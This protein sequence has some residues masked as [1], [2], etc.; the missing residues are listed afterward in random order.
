MSSEKQ[1][2]Y[3]INNPA[4]STR[5][6]H[7]DNPDFRSVIDESLTLVVG[8]RGGVKINEAGKT[9]RIT[10]SELPEYLSQ[11]NVAGKKF[12]CFD[13]VNVH[14]KLLDHKIKGIQEATWKLSATCSLWDVCLLQQQIAWITKGQA[15]PFPKI[16]SLFMDYKVVLDPKD[17]HEG[18]RELMR[19]QFDFLVEN[20]PYLKNDFVGRRI[21][22]EHEYDSLYIDPTE[23]IVSRRNVHYKE[24][25]WPF[26]GLIEG[27]GKYGPAAVGIEVQGAIVADHLSRTA[28]LIC[29]DPSVFYDQQLKIAKQIKKDKRIASAYPNSEAVFDRKTGEPVY[30]RK[31][32]EK[33]THLWW[34]ETKPREEQNPNAE[35]RKQDARQYRLYPL[36][37]CASDNKTADYCN[38]QHWAD[39][40]P[41]IGP[42]RLWADFDAVSKA[43]HHAETK[44]QESVPYESFPFLGSE[45]VDFVDRT[46]ESPFFQAALG[47]K[48]VEL[49]I[50][51]LDLFCFSLCNGLQD[52]GAIHDNSGTFGDYLTIGLRGKANLDEE[53]FELV[54]YEASITNHE[55]NTFGWDN[56]LTLTN[57]RF[58][59]ESKAIPSLGY[60]VLSGILFPDIL[61]SQSSTEEMNSQLDK[62]SF[63][64]NQDWMLDLNF[65]TGLEELFNRGSLCLKELPSWLQNN[66][67]Y[68]Q[69]AQIVVE[70]FIQGHSVDSV[71]QYCQSRFNHPDIPVLVKNMSG[72]LAVR[73]TYRDYDSL[74]FPWM[75]LVKAGIDP[76]VTVPDLGHFSLIVDGQVLVVGATE[77]DAIDPMLRRARFQ[78]A[79]RNTLR[80]RSSKEHRQIWTEQILPIF[81]ERFEELGLPT[82]PSSEVYD[83]FY[84]TSSLSVTG[85]PGRP[86]YEIEKAYESRA[87]FK[88]D[89]LKSGA[90][91]LLRQ[92]APLVA[93]TRNGFILH[94]PEAQDSED[95]RRKYADIIHAVIRGFLA[96]GFR[97]KTPEEY[98]TKPNI[99]PDIT[100]DALDS[101]PRPESPGFD[102]AENQQ[103]RL[104]TCFIAPFIGE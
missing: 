87:V 9:Q 59:K 26:L 70:S 20:L 7:C 10:S 81:C 36:D 14:N 74:A 64:L 55:Y 5:Y 56:I 51:S 35:E 60:T 43:Y 24:R 39:N 15:I 95:N 85:K 44:A 31:A 8:K 29:I 13:A 80:G 25:L 69:L 91:A 52:R 1:K 16:E 98:L 62:V 96:F 6:L 86:V 84:K 54:R 49:K 100:I 45:I 11:K 42:L 82:E 27:W 57:L 65:H 83:F 37:P 79:V 67:T 41:L 90:Y 47:H 21:F 89:I 17:P 101:W 32:G 77:E 38:P 104:Q 102:S 92:G 22:R 12:I 103:Q 66:D 63:F 46:R 88:D 50:C 99:I 23:R 72:W 58:F 61:L 19:R 34:D 71:V 94:L 40:I 53:Q 18:L 73:T 75:F 48:L 28:S 68:L 33:I 30:S 4:F 78:A 97:E 2:V 93:V 76:C 3:A